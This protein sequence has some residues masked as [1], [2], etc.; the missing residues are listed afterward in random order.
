MSDVSAAIAAIKARI[1]D[2]PTPWPQGLGVYAGDPDEG[3]ETPYVCIWDQ[4]D[5]AVRGKAT[6][7]VQRSRLPFQLSCVGR[8]REGVLE[9]VGV[10]RCVR[11]WAPVAGASRIVEDGSN[12]IMPEGT[13]SDVRY[14]APLTMH[15]YLP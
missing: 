6:G 9:V 13:G 11:D 14:V 7:A 12:A 15:C 3:A 4:T 10:V 5:S 8:T 2:Q 1:K